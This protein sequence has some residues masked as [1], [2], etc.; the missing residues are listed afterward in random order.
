MS[1]EPWEPPDWLDMSK[2]C[3]NCGMPGPDDA[4]WDE[5]LPATVQEGEADG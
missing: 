5:P 2:P 3:P 4:E 1:A